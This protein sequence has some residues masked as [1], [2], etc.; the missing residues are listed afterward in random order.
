VFHVALFVKKRE[1]NFFGEREESE[2][3]TSPMTYGPSCPK[4]KVTTLAA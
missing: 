2:F 1:K 4:K 3:V